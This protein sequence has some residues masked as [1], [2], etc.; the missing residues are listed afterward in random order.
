MGFWSVTGMPLHLFGLG[1]GKQRLLGILFDIAKFSHEKAGAFGNKA[2]R[3]TAAV[4][5]DSS[6]RAQQVLSVRG[7]VSKIQVMH[8]FLYVVDM[9]WSLVTVALGN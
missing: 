5:S 8:Q 1:I 9:E 3:Y 2:I 4:P 7:N 6:K